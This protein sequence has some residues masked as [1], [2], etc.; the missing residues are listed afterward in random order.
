MAEDNYGA[1]ILGISEVAKLLLV[2]Y[3]S[4]SHQRNMTEEQIRAE[5]EA[6]RVK[7]KAQSA[8][9]LPEV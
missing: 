1:A 8:S 6:E 2:A 5:L 4:L 3:F 7:F 9:R